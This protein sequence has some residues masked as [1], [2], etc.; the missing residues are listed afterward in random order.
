MDMRRIPLILWLG[1]FGILVAGYFVLRGFGFLTLS[2]PAWSKPVPP[3]DQEIAYIQ[4]ATN[5]A[6]WER[7]VAGIRRVKKEWPELIVDDRK[8]FP[9]QSAAVPE[10]VLSVPG[11]SG[12]LWIR[13]YKLTSDGGTQ[14]WI[15]ELAR[16]DP[17]PLA[18]IGGGSSDRARDLARALAEQKDWQGSRPVLL[19]TTATA[20]S[21]YPGGVDPFPQSLMSLYDG[22]S[23]R[24][25]FTN[26]QMAEAIWNFV[27]TRDDLRP[28]VNQ[29]PLLPSGI[30]QALGGDIWGSLPLLAW[31]IQQ[32]Q[33]YFVH[34]VE[35]LD[36]PYS[37]DLANQF[38]ALFSNPDG[39]AMPPNRLYVAYS[40]GGLMTPNPREEIAVRNLIELIRPWREA[41]FLLIL[42]AV[43][44]PVRRFLRTLAVAGPREVR[45]VVAVTGDSIS[46]NTLCHNRHFAW[47]VQELPVP[48]I[49]FCHHNPVAWDG[50]SPAWALPGGSSGLVQAVPIGT[51]EELLNADIVR[52]LVEAV[53]N[54][55]IVPGRLPQAILVSSPSIVATGDD[56][57]DQIRKRRKDYFG[58]NGNRKG[59][60]GEYIVVLTPHFAAHGN[61]LPEA[62][63]EVW[64]R[65]SR[66]PMHTVWE[67]AKKLDIDYR[68]SRR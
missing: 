1:L 49:A 2:T 56:L 50:D 19:I 36:D 28:F 3:G 61:V 5:S 62:T 42:P 34:V 54:L 14:T 7:F 10:V 64:F 52:L 22:R 8:A 39:L 20:D 66:D 15:R 12:K 24:F 41:R 35:W 16:R 6:S 45:N 60:S 40:V 33:P 11:A 55:D 9:D 53:F 27:W 23:W 57:N 17:A 38:S 13:W 51:D 21:I 44:K 67:R 43:D 47:N 48:V 46:F 59:G 63:V 18:V 32:P 65:R 37:R 58:P 31:G 29:Y 25:C 30:A 26:S 4:A 68:E